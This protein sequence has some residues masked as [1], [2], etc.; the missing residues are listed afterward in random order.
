MAMTKKDYQVLASAFAVQ[1]RAIADRESIALQTLDD[2]IDTIAAHLVL[3]N[4]RFNVERFLEVAR[5]KSHS[6]D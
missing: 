2:T 5:D 4:D 1:R 3:L 6:D